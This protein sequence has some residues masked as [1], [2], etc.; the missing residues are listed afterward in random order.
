MVAA[1]NERYHAG[2]AGLLR[3]SKATKFDGGFRVPGIFRFPGRIPAGKVTADIANTMDIYI[4]LMKLAEGDLPTD[5]TYDGN[6]LMTFLEGKS[7][8]PTDEFYF[9]VAQRIQGLRK[10][11]WKLVIKNEGSI[12][13]EHSDFEDVKLYNLDLDPGERYD[14][15]DKE[16]EIVDELKQQ[17][18]EFDLQMLNEDLKRKS[19]P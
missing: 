14:F 7:K 5:L 1:G 3:G 17:I 11:P 9:I 16:P 4:T 15:S 18:A 19:S 12:R 10:G 13:I 2:N 8:S 6:D